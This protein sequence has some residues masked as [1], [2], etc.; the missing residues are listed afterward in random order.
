MRPARAPV[1]LL[2][3]AFSFLVP[4][5]AH[6]GSGAG[7]FYQFDPATGSYTY[8]QTGNGWTIPTDSVAGPV[9]YS[10][11]P[12]PKN[13][14]LSTRPP[15]NADGWWGGITFFC[16]Q[17][18]DSACGNQYTPSGS[19]YGGLTATKFCQIKT[20]DANSV[21]TLYRFRGFNSRDNNSV[22]VWDG[23]NWSYV[24]TSVWGWNVTIN[25]I[26]CKSNANE[27]SNTK[28]NTKPATDP[29]P[30]NGDWSDWSSCS[31]SCGG[32]T[33]SRLCNSPYPTNGGADCG[34]P[35]SQSCNPEAC[36]SSDLPDLVAGSVTPAAAVPGAA[37]TLSAPIT[38]QGGLGTGGGFIDLFEINPAGVPAAFDGIQTLRNYQS[39][40]LAPGAGNTMTAQYS[41]ASAGIYYVRACADLG[42]GNAGTIAESDENNNCSDWTPIA[43]AVPPP[44]CAVAP[45]D[46]SCT[47]GSP[48]CANPG[49]CGPGAYCSAHAS[50][51]ACLYCAAHPSNPSCGPEIHIAHLSALM[52]AVSPIA[53]GSS[54]TLTYACTDAA[55]AAIDHGVGAVSAGDAGGTK[56]VTPSA[57]TAYTLTCT[58]SSGHDAWY[59]VTV[60]VNAPTLSLTA[61]PALV[62]SGDTSVISWSASGKVDSCAM[63]GPNLS[64]HAS[65]GSL[66]QII[67][68]ESTY[69]FSCS[70][71]SYHPSQSVTVKLTPGYKEI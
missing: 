61:S 21:A 11:W 67:Q 20:G 7:T 22:G 38:N 52:N 45:S 30:I 57:D 65:S 41:F 47:G 4:P 53:Y 50:D 17:G 66:P 15:N 27:K 51:P 12:S 23:S 5:V 70:A 6:A 40:A 29:I 25:G 18:Q 46:L 42:T 19:S 71:G 9:E 35:S 37:I 36:P 8:V 69:L 58:D 28:S 68:T 32:G 63:T 1:L 24:R 2:L 3:F 44:S 55:S 16:Q 54:S 64:S 26:T 62:R 33:Q 59:T 13:T 60:R 56:K 43:V 31:A 10:E 49:G 34:G 39:D 14:G 48:S